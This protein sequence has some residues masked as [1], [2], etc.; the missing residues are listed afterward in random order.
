MSQQE[1]TGRREDIG[2]KRPNRKSMEPRKPE[3]SGKPTDPKGS[4]GSTDGEDTSP[5]GFGGKTTLISRIITGAV[6]IVTVAACLFAGSISSMVLIAVLNAFCCYE[7]CRMMH[8][9]GRAHV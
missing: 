5:A 6:L 3:R 4:V 7:F 1:Q 8:K 2:S 9:I